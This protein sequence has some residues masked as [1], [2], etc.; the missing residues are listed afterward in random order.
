MNRGNFQ[1]TITAYLCTKDAARAIEFYKRA[2]GAV[3]R[4]RIMDEDGKRVSHAEMSIG[5]AVFF[6]ADEYP[7][8][9]LS[10]QTIGGSPVLLVLDVPD[11]DAVFQQAVSAG[12]SIARPL[13]DAF[14]G[15]LRNGKLI[16]PFGHQWMI[17]T[18]VNPRKLG[19]ELHSA[20]ESV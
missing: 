6:L 5:A 13:Q 17:T 18:T 11:V 14:N 16:D 10:P 19:M 2:F 3:E 7:D 20:S 1:N 12:A 9:V 4:V 8:K 15:A